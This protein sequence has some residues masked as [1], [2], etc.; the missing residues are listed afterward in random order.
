MELYKAQCIQEGRLLGKAYIQTDKSEFVLS[1]FT[2][3]NSCAEAEEAQSR[4]EELRDDVYAEQRQSLLHNNDQEMSEL[5]QQK[6]DH[7]SEFK[8]SW[9]QHEK[10]LIESSQ[11]DIAA[12]EEAHAAQ[13]QQERERIEASLSTVYKPSSHLLNSRN[14][15]ERLIKQ[16]KYAEA[17]QLKAEIEQQEVDEQARHMDQREVKV[18]KAMS[19]VLAKQKIEMQALNKKLVNQQH[20]QRRQRDVETTQ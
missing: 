12:L 20:E 18:T 10:Q 7:M 11:Q 2:A 1:L 16:K 13:L 19:K 8:S 6:E 4:I 9:D 17:H 5:L 15:F 14:V 3:A